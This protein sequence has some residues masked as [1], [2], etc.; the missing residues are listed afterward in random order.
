VS[1][2]AK[3]LDTEEKNSRL[4]PPGGNSAVGELAA[5]VGTERPPLME[6]D[7]SRL[8]FGSLGPAAR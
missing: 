4:L 3:A 1:R 8:G 2:A 5:D 7:S 6:S